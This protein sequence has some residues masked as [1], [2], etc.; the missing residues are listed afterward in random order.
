MM[1]LYYAL[2]ILATA[3][4]FTS[5]FKQD[6][7]DC[8]IPDNLVLRIDLPDSDGSSILAARIKS[9]DAF[10]YD[11]DNQFVAHKR[12]QQDINNPFTDIAFTVQPG[13]YRVV[14]WG[15][16]SDHSVISNDGRL[17][18]DEN[19]IETLSDVTGDALYYAPDINTRDKSISRA[20]L[21]VGD[22]VY[23]AHT[24]VVPLNKVT[25]KAMSFTRAHRTIRVFMKEYESQY[26]A[27]APYVRFTNMPLRTD[28]L[29]QTDWVRKDY[30][31]L[32]TQVDTE[33]GERLMASFNTQISSFSD[34]MDIRIIRSSDNSTVAVIGLKK[35]IQDNASRIK[36]LNEINIEIIFAADG[37][38]YV[39]FPPW[40]NNPLNPEW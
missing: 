20:T 39:Q 6:L 38:L 29:L 4:L 17:S 1:K 23:Q 18:L 21:Q 16:V 40:Q 27:Q 30:T 25:V 31:A 37:A 7:S 13:E 22:P 35:Y 32:S 5:C 19:K 15:N 34:D 36:D 14:C 9:I 3:L 33:K 8:S 12:I 26:E 2:F 28:F 10:V 11:A 24:A